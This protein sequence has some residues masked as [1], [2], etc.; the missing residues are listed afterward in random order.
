MTTF[1]QFSARAKLRHD[2]SDQIQVRYPHPKGEQFDTWISGD[3]VMQRLDSQA[4]E[5]LIRSFSQL[6]LDQMRDEVKGLVDKGRRKAGRSLRD[7]L[8]GAVSDGIGDNIFGD[9]MA[10]KL[11]GVDSNEDPDRL[12]R[13]LWQSR[14]QDPAFRTMALELAWI[15]LEGTLPDEQ[16]E[17]LDDWL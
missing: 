6:N 15:N 16:E 2:F 1:K 3:E 11:R 13:Q 12:E 17:A 4:R 5:R 10:D 8:A 7:R 14:L 9:T